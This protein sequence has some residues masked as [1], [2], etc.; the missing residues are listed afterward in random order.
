[1]AAYGRRSVRGDGDDIRVYSQFQSDPF[2]ELGVYV[3]VVG[4][5]DIPGYLIRVIVSSRG[6]A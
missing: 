3:C 1:M 2:R 4:Y 6:S 5:L